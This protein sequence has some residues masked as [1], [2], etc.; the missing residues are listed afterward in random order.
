MC[1]SLAA[2]HALAQGEA[3]D[4]E[5]RVEYGRALY[6]SYCATCHGTDGHG[7][8]PAAA[9]LKTKPADL[10]LLRRKYGRPL[11]REQL[12]TFIDGRTTLAS[13]GSREMPIWGERLY[14]DE[15]PSDDLEQRKVGSIVL[16]LDYIVS[17][18]RDDAP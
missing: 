18:Q 17:I 3:D 6:L 7:A 2:G 11:P 12:A 4:P 8:G 16:L 13:H 5:F 10:T 15:P 1:A 14:E 9:A